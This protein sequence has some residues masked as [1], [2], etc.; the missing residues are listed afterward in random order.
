LNLIHELDRGIEYFIGKFEQKKDLSTDELDRMFAAP[1]D[2]H[3]WT[4]PKGSNNITP[5]QRLCNAKP[6]FM[7]TSRL[8]QQVQIMKTIEVDDRDLHTQ[9][10]EYY[11]SLLSAGVKNA[12]NRGKSCSIR[13]AKIAVVGQ[14]QAGKTSMIRSLK[15][16]PFNA[17]C[18]STKLVDVA[19]VADVGIH[20]DH[21]NLDE[22][23]KGGNNIFEPAKKGFSSELQRAVKKELLD[24]HNKENGETSP[25]DKTIQTPI[26]SPNSKPPNQAPTKDPADG[27]S[28]SSD[29]HIHD[30]P[31]K[32]VEKAEIVI[33]DDDHGDQLRVAIWDNG[34]QDVFRSVQHLYMTRRCVYIVVFNLTDFLHNNSKEKEKAM[35]TITFWLHSIKYHAI[36][37]D[38]K[39]LDDLSKLYPP[40][41]LV[42]THLDQ[43][44]EFTE[45]KNN[46]SDLMRSKLREIND[47][48]V[49][50]LG[51]LAL[52]ST[53]KNSREFLYNSG[54]SLCFWP[55]NNS[56][57]KDPNVPK[58]RDLSKRAIL[59]D[60]IEYINDKIPISWLSAI[61][62][63][64]EICFNQEIPLIR[65]DDSDHKEQALTN[66][67]ENRPD[68]KEVAVV[69]VLNKHGAFVKFD[70][71]TSYSSKCKEE[72]VLLGWLFILILY[73]VF[74]TIAS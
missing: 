30:P 26:L 10:N 71:N 62:E 19:D 5:L 27:S 52:F 13:R 17:A 67:G 58:L 68:P 2:V 38:P 64:K 34:G 39:H 11:K 45:K 32:V 3:F 18:P 28:P 56:N 8:L 57:P 42:G 22:A 54:Q 43:M 72:A 47:I 55:I 7:V 63:L 36:S 74:K 66:L 49:K 33:N 24:R 1:Y 29:D 73:L 4:T 9:I 21:I 20:V 6:P 41:V 35:E 14:G 31:P 44:K 51:S 25:N 12:I 59:E 15:G 50:E 70:K 37:K 53:E 23:N 40:V 60:P 69:S 46:R 48:L 65:L 16:L 61:D